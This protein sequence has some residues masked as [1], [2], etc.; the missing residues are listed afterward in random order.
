MAEDEERDGPRPLVLIVGAAAL[1]LV[2]VVAVIAVISLQSDGTP[3]D[4]SAE[5]VATARAWLR[6]W[7]HDDRKAMQRLVAP[8]SPSV[9]AVIGGFRSAVEPG[10]IDASP[11]IIPTIDGERATVPFH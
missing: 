7:T 8:D 3:R 6:A 11:A 2:L 9:D 10:K 1:L 4:R 5:A